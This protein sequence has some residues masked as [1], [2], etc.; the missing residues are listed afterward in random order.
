MGPFSKNIFLTFLKAFTSS[1]LQGHQAP[2][3]S[4]FKTL[5]ISA[6]YL[7]EEDE[8]FADFTRPWI[9]PKFPLRLDF[10]QIS[11]CKD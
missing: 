3:N 2:T 1:L 6:D 11:T 4:I 10:Q 5:T 7:S 8:A 9:F